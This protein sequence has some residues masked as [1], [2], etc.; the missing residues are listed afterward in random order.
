NDVFT[1]EGKVQ[2]EKKSPLNAKV[3]F[4]RKSTGEIVGTATTNPATGGYT[5]LLPTGELY[6]IVASNS[7]YL[8][9]NEEIDAADAASGSTVEK[10]ITLKELAVGDVLRL[11]QLKFGSGSFVIEPQ[12][13]SEL[14]RM[15]KL[16]KDNPDIT[17]EI[18][19]HTDPYGDAEANAY[20]SKERAKSVKQYFV[21]QGIAEER[22]TTV[23]MG[24]AQPIAPNTPEG[25]QLN[26][27]VE[28]KILTK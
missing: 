25:N 15:A 22:M 17:V 9:L 14:D 27:R 16:L 6:T 13:Y 5:M 23:G 4:L 19:G 28:L 11:S 18:S 10:N 12:S 21:E 1:V 26:R 8:S 20:F 7:G 3:V 2:D 24:S